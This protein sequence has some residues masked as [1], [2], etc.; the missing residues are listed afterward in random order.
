MGQPVFLVPVPVSASS[1]YSFIN[2]QFDVAPAGKPLLNC[3][4]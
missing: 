4:A 3:T 2:V 1:S